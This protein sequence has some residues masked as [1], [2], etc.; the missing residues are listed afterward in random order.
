MLKNNIL[1]FLDE[2]YDNGTIQDEFFRT[3]NELDSLLFQLEEKIMQKK[4]NE[5]LK[6]LFIALQSKVEEHIENTKNKYFEYGIN[7]NFEERHL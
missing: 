7:I 5:E 6:R 2:C 1:D 3:K 4:Q